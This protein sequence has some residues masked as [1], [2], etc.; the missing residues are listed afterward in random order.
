[1]KS[2]NI[3]QLFAFN[4][5]RTFVQIISN[6]DLRRS[7]RINNERISTYYI[8]RRLSVVRLALIMK[9]ISSC[10]S[11]HMYGFTIFLPLIFHVNDRLSCIILREK[12]YIPEQFMFKK[13]EFE[14]EVRMIKKLYEHDS[15][16]NIIKVLRFGELLDSSY[17]FINMKPREMNLKD[18]KFRDSSPSDFISHFIKDFP[19]SFKCLQIWDIMRQIADNIVFIH[20][21][22]EMYSVEMSRS[23]DSTRRFNGMSHKTVGIVLI[24][25]DW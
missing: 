10:K 12:S 18:Y 16:P 13:K 24:Y 6:H 19:S 4:S 7:F 20:S 1:M 22:G 21:H 8:R 23:F 14:N 25:N 17:Y 2:F 5:S 9:H 15:H 11:S 3:H